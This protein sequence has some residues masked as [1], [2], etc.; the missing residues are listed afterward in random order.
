MKVN[1]VAAVR[2]ATLPGALDLLDGHAVETRAGTLRLSRRGRSLQIRCDPCRLQHADLASVPVTVP[3]VLE[4]R[5]DEDLLVG[6]LAAEDVRIS[7]NGRLRSDS[8]ELAW[9]LPSTELTALYRVLRE[10]VPEAALA[11]IEGSVQAEGSLVLPSLHTRAAWHGEGWEVT[12]LGTEQLR[13]G[14]FRLACSGAAG[15]STVL[16]GDGEKTWAVADAMGPYLAAAV[17]A[18]EDQRFPQH[19]GYDEQAISDVLANIEDGRPSRG[20]STITQQLARTLFTGG[21]RTAARKL[22]ELLYTIEMERT[23]GKAR[24]LELYLNTVDWGPG[25]CG[26]KAAARAYFGKAPV[27]L[28]PIEA[29]WLAS[30]LRNPHAAWVQRMEMR[31]PSRERAT[32]VLMQMRDWPRRD[33]RRFARQTLAF[34]PPATATNPM[35]GTPRRAS[36]PAPVRRAQP[37][38]SSLARFTAGQ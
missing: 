27:R 37:D 10:A 13:F 24:I 9:R 23:L 26:A 3:V 1:V 20:A 4:L 14:P 5:R 33:R 36:S 11:R 38:T 6:L 25:L 16:T 31:Q 35:T 15:W 22:R 12:G 7:F 30:V 18:A 28:T 34:A 2:L 32:A 29:A 19:G 17:I 21:E 8:I